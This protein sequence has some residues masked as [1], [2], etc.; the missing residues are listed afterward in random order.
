MPKIMSWKKG[1]ETVKL[2]RRYDRVW[3]QSLVGAGAG[4]RSLWRHRSGRAQ[5]NCEDHFRVESVLPRRRVVRGDDDLLAQ[6]RGSGWTVL[7]GVFD[8]C[9]RGV[10]LSDP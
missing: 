2:Y 8:A 9:G 5:E 7:H 1:Q 10:P 6:L 4:S 3:N